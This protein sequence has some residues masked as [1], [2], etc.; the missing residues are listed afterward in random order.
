MTV[1]L[2]F[3]TLNF[4]FISRIKILFSFYMIMETKEHSPLLSSQCASSVS[5]IPVAAKTLIF[6]AQSNYLSQ[7]CL[8][9]RD[10]WICRDSVAFY[11]CCSSLSEKCFP[12]QHHTVTVPVVQCDH[13]SV[14]SSALCE[15]EPGDIESSAAQLGADITAIYNH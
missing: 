15:S 9:H 8:C 11:H 1:T 2:I 12:S 14:F 4:N 3:P 6:A 7:S 5:C 13:W 10:F